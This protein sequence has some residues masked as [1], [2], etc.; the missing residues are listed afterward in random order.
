MNPERVPSPRPA[1][2][3]PRLALAWLAV[4][5]AGAPVLA[6]DPD[7]EIAEDPAL[8]E[9]LKVFDEAV[10]DR[11]MERDQEAVGIID[12]LLT[13]HQD[14]MHPKDEQA[15]QKSLE[16]VFTARLRKPYQPQLY[17]ASVA[18]LG[19]IGGPVSSRI[20]VKLVDRK[21]FPDQDWTNLR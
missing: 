13:Q 15:F 6:Q 21:P 2:R 4:L 5:L 19:K 3:A 8:P 16:K 20:L 11:K 10:R 1:R 12:E 17:A 9:K 14:G 18:A 7:K